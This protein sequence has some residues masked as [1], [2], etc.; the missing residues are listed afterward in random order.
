MNVIEIEQL[1]ALAKSWVGYKEKRSMDYSCYD[2]KDDNA[3]MSNWTRFGRIADICIGN[4]DRRVKDGYPWCAM[5]LLSCL[6][7][8]KAGRIDCTTH[9]GSIPTNAEALWFVRKVANDGGQLTYFAGVAAWLESYRRRHLVCKVPADGDFVVYLDDNG[10]PY[11]IGL[12]YEV[13]TD[14]TIVTI[15]GNTSSGFGDKVI[16][17]GGCVDKKNRKKNA[18][19]L[20]LQNNF[21]SL[22]R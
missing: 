6:Y 9:A 2:L 21:I 22:R 4:V 16:A 5:F 11:H 15:E 12:V 13:K 14:G 20:F 18:K 7:E 17:N 10:K 1:K 19:M 8:L 3:G